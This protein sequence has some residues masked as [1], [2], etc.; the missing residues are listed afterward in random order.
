MHGPESPSGRIVPLDQIDPDDRYFAVT[1]SW[2]LDDPIL[3]AAI[4]RVGILQPLLLQAVSDLRYRIVVGFK[5][6]R[7]ARRLGFKTLPALVVGDESDCE[8]LMKAVCDNLGARTLSPIEAAD[9]VARLKSFGLAVDALLDDVLPLL[10]F[11]SKRHQLERLLE[12]ARLP[13]SLKE[14]ATGRLG[15]DLALSLAA[16]LPDER[17]V[18]IEAVDELQLGVN[19]QKQVFDLLADIRTRDGRDVAEVWR[20]SAAES[21]AADRSVSPAQ[22]FAQ[23]KQALRRLR[24]PALSEHESRL[25]ALKRELALPPNIRLELPPYF[26]GT[27]IQVVLTA[28]KAEEL[29]TAAERLGV[30]AKKREMEAIFDLL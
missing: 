7:A 16:W 13:D 28:G 1:P 17:R 11:P 8:L 25:D 26:E 10:G 24:F 23:V 22:R 12:V 6:C 19:K 9:T 18:F 29:R 30:A 4:R 3:E 14:A 15:L 21:R 5:R 27:R 20:S 2:Q